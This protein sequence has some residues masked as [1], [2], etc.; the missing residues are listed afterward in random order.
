MP[1]PS[2]STSTTVRSSPRRRVA[3]RPPRSWRRARSPVN[4][5]V[6]STDPAATPS[7]VDAIPS[8]P[9]APRLARI[10]RGRSSVGRN[11]SR[12]RIGIE[13]ATTR[14]APAGRVRCRAATTAGSSNGPSVAMAATVDMA[15]ES[16]PVHVD[17]QGPACCTSGR[18]STSR[19]ASR[20][21]SAATRSVTRW[22][23]SGNRPRWSTATRRSVPTRSSQSRYPLLVGMAPIWTTRSG[24]WSLAQVERS[25]WSPE[26][27]TGAS[28]VCGPRRRPDAG[29]AR[30]GQP[31]RRDSS[32]TAATPRSSGSIGP[33]T[34]R[35]RSVPRRPGS[36]PGSTAA[37]S[38]GMGR[39]PT[40]GG[41]WTGG[42][43]G[44]RNP[45]LTCT[46]PGAG[47]VA[48]TTAWW[49]SEAAS[50][51]GRVPATA[52]VVAQRVWVP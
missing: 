23:G 28:A 44:S 9:L 13:L 46:G 12:S 36:G 47:R 29:S 39:R 14:L 40:G 8:I 3:R 31:V 32:A 51:A 21:G 41:S 15:T 38:G 20:P 22:A 19:A 27:S 6:G 33:A 49:A 2:L 45:M 34:S 24:R 30:T 11:A 16:A 25:R 43:S 18:C 42:S 26:A 10:R 17:V 7:A 37:W 35:P 50:P 1:P 52:S 5:T 4:R 48:R